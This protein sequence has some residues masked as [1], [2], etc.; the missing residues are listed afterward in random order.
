MLISGWEARAEKRVV[1]VANSSSSICLPLY[2]ENIHRAKKL[3]SLKIRA[4][5]HYRVVTCG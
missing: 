1:Q 5:F 3:P 2:E 4:A